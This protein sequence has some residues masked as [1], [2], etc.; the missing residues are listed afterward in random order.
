MGD[1]RYTCRDLMGN[2]GDC[3]RLENLGVDRKV[4]L[5]RILKCV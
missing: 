1:R 5:K 3:D 2:L 4:I